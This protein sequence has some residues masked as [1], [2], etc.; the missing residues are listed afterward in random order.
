MVGPLVAPRCRS[1]PESIDNIGD[2]QHR[3]LSYRFEVMLEQRLVPLV[4]YGIVPTSCTPLTSS[5]HRSVIAPLLNGKISD[6]EDESELSFALIKMRAG[7]HRV[8]AQ[9]LQLEAANRFLVQRN[10]NLVKEVNSFRVQKGLTTNECLRRPIWMIIGSPMC[11]SDRTT[12]KAHVT[13][14][15]SS[16]RSR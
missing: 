6:G 1:I 10:E 4:P 8:R 16:S 13:A 2:E 7:L 9:N 12:S 14:G 5:M 3:Q 11:P 15:G